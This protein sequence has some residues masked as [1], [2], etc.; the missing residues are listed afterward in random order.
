MEHE[1]RLLNITDVEFLVNFKEGKINYLRKA[2]LFPYGEKIGKH[3]RWTLNEIQTWISN[4]SKNMKEA[5]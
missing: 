4:P 2:G 3:R 1:I 5:A